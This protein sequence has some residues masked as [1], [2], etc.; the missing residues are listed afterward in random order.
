MWCFYTFIGALIWLKKKELQHV[1]C[2]IMKQTYEVASKL[3]DYITMM[4][5]AGNS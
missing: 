5:R 1:P 2:G 4:D 3:L